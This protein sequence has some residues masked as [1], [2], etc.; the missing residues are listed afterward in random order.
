[1]VK[2]LAGIDIRPDPQEGFYALCCKHVQRSMAREIISPRYGELTLV[3][4][5]GHT[6]KLRSKCIYSY[7]HICATL[8]SG[9]KHI[10]LQ[11]VVINVETPNCL[12]CLF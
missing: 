12:K 1:M 11:W 9:G 2:L 8:N 6:V 4:L 7:A 3:L 10:F 5:N